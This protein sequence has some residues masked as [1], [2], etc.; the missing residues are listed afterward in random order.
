MGLGLPGARGG[1]V[2]GVV[3][4]RGTGLWSGEEVAG[5]AAGGAG[6]FCDGAKRVEEAVLDGVLFVEAAGG[7]GASAVGTREAGAVV[8]LGVGAAGVAVFFEVSVTLVSVFFPAPVLVVVLDFVDPVFFTDLSFTSAG[9][10]FTAVVALVDAFL[11][12]EALALAAVSFGAAVAIP[13]TASFV[14][15][16]F[17]GRVVET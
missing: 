11:V 7:S 1:T 3:C 17:F 16:A 14:A 9:S 5:S 10:F 12:F 8:I 2:L 6:Y 15:F 13:L 4:G